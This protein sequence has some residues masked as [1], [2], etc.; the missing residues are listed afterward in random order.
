LTIEFRVEP[1]IAD[2]PLIGVT[3]YRCIEGAALGQNINKLHAQVSSDN[4]KLINQLEKVGYEIVENS[5][6]ILIKRL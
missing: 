5:K 1:V 3:L 4:F 2:N 6:T